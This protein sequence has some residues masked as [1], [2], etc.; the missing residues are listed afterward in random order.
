M[1][2]RI[3]VPRR[4][5]LSTLNKID[6]FLLGSEIFQMS[7]A[8]L[9]TTVYS[10]DDSKSD[11]CHWSSNAP[12]VTCRKSS[13]VKDA[14]DPQHATGDQAHEQLGSDLP[15]CHWHPHSW[16]RIVA[17]FSDNSPVLSNTQVGV[18]QLPSCV[19]FVFW[20]SDLCRWR[21]CL[22]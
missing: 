22:V 4:H 12:D 14:T 15:K 17:C 9:L 8:D 5:C 19:L 18:I 11:A 20:T 2:R 16:T 3:L 7:K 10:P 13:A 1:A 21:E 6:R